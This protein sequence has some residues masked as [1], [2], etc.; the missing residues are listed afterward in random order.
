MR[1]GLRSQS[2]GCQGPQTALNQEVYAGAW[3]KSLEASKRGWGETASLA[4]W[5]LPVCKTTARSKTAP[6]E[7]LGGGRMWLCFICPRR[8]RPYAGGHLTGTQ[9]LSVLAAQSRGA[10]PPHTPAWV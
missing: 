6:G 10:P 8:D 7:Q 5:D 9:A 1:R 2:G 3:G 4:R